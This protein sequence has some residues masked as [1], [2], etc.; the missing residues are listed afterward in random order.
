MTTKKRGMPDAEL[1]FDDRVA[2]ITVR[3]RAGSPYALLL[4]SGVQR[5][6]STIRVPA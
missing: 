6:S 2:V 1:R 5:S 4:A 3:K